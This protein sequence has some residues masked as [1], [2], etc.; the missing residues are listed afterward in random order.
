ML[1]VPRSVEEEE[2]IW[3]NGENM[4]RGTLE[5]REGGKEHP[6]E[7]G[8]EFEVSARATNSTS[9]HR[10]GRTRRHWAA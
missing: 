4:E 8:K 6:K 1:R 7:G 5:T 3:S 2:E 10:A 9:M